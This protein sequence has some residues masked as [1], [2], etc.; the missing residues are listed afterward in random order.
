MAELFIPLPQGPQ[1]DRFC[2]IPQ[3]AVVRIPKP[4]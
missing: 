1:Q 3:N 4:Y 2:D